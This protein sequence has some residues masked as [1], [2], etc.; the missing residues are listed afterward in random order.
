MGIRIYVG[1]L[2]TASKHMA[3]ILYNN[4]ELLDNVDTAF[5]SSSHNTLLHI[6]SAIKAIAN[7]DDETEIRDQ[8]MHSLTYGR[9][10]KRLLLVNPNFVGNVAHPFGKELFYLR[11]SG[12]IYQLQKLFPNNSLQLFSSTRSP[13]TFLPSCHAQSLLAASFTSYSEFLAEV[14]L[15]NLKWSP[16]LQRLEGKQNDMSL[17]VGR[18]ED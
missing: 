12:L 8:L 18:Y 9:D 2:R 14:N 15:L 11:T 6:N 5:Y 17:T 3:S 10:V 13:T 4:L 16:F 1:P 7:G